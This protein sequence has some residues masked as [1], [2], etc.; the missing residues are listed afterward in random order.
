MKVTAADRRITLRHDLKTAL[1]IRL[2]KSSAPEQ[3]SESVNLSE[4]G[5]LYV[6]DAAPQIGAVIEVLLKMPEEI[7]GEPATEWH[8]LGHVVRV[9]PIDSP[10]GKVGVGVQFDCYQLARKLELETGA[11]RSESAGPGLRVWPVRE[12]NGPSSARK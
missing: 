11:L 8:C 2:W 5:I 12:T 7:T 4:R 10:R 6:T 3:R 1:R 9:V